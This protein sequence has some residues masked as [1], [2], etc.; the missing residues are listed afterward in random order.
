MRAAVV[1]EADPVT[2]DAHRVLDGLKTVAMHALLLQRPDEAF[3]HA[4]LLG[5]VWGDELLLQTVA[6]G[7]L[8]E[9]VAGEDQTVVRPQQ[10]LFLDLAQSAEPGDQGVL[11]GGAGGRGFA[12]LRQMPAQQ[13]AGVAV[14]HQRQ[15]SPAVLARPDTG[16]IRRPALVRRSRNRR[17]HSEIADGA[18]GAAPGPSRHRRSARS[19]RS[20]AWQGQ[21]SAPWLALYRS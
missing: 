14:D 16:E 7:D 1:V 18:T 4:V 13:L 19:D 9:V 20:D 8:G 5:T 3:D 10:E 11:E 2:D 6:A 21:A 17:H 12:G 15:G